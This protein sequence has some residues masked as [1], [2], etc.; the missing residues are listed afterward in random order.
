MPK[1][2]SP[3]DAHAYPGRRRDHGQSSVQRGGIARARNCCVRQIPGIVADDARGRRMGRRRRGARRCLRRTSPAATSSSPRCCFSTTTPRRAAGAGARGAIDCDA[4]V[5]CMSAGEVVE[6]T[7]VGKF[8]MSGEAR[9]RASRW[10]KT[11]ARQARA[12]RPAARQR[13]DEDA[14]PAAETAALHSRHRAGRARLFP[15]AAILARR[16]RRE[17]RQHG[18]PAGRSLCGRPAPRSARRRQG[19]AADS[20][21]PMSASII[22]ACRDASPKRAE[23]LPAAGRR[24]RRPSVCCCMRSY[25]LAGNAG[26]YD[27]VIAA[28]EAKRAARHS[29]LRQRAR[30]APG[31]RTLL[32]EG[33][34]SPP[35]MRWFR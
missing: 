5:C 31:D 19:R 17:H 28:L 4:M 27:G 23:H 26:H 32:H 6:L 16:L 11:A 3:A 8:D 18:P 29:R 13:R 2:I 10:L 33:W 14:A 20:T 34:P 12:R 21:I 35:S 7:R 30:P 24:A 9:R 25:V 22:R 15:D 1:R